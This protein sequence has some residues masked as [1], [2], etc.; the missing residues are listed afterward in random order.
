MNT[1]ETAKLSPAERIATTVVRM[2]VDDVTVL[3]YAYLDP[4]RGVVGGSLHVDA[5][6]TGY[7]DEESVVFDFSYAKKQIKATIDDLCD[8]RLALPKEF[9]KDLGE[10]RCRVD[11]A[12]GSKLA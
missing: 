2:F 1:K 4:I 11:F 5:E 8:H 9:V 7:L 6:L 10:G 12:Y 3:D